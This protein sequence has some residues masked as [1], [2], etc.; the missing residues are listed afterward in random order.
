M[1][2]L[3]IP[4]A[5]ATAATVAVVYIVCAVSVLL[6]PDIAMTIARSWFHGIDIS[7][8]TLSAQTNAGSLVLG[9]LTATGGGWL[10]GLIFAHAYNYFAKQ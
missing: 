9:F 5:N 3:P 7:A 4:T 10:L 6:F 8:L 2:H 1:K